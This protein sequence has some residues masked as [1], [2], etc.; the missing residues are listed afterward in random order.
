MPDL[1]VRKITVQAHRKGYTRGKDPTLELP[2][3]LEDEAYDGQLPEIMTIDGRDDVPREIA[4][5][6][7]SVDDD[8]IATPAG[9]SATAQGQATTASVTEAALLAPEPSISSA[10]FRELHA[11]RRDAGFL[12]PSTAATPEEHSTRHG[13]RWSRRLSYCATSEVIMLTSEKITAN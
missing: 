3:I 8:E 4:Q 11:L 1:V 5:H 7:N 9:A 6:E 10:G 12:E 13:I 2:D